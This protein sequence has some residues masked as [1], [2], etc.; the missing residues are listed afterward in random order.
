VK[1]QVS[2]L[3]RDAGLEVSET[4]NVTVSGGPE[5]PQINPVKKI[6]DSLASLPA[7]TIRVATLQARFSSPKQ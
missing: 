5:N 4:A 7:S 2:E 1:K 3:L 6:G